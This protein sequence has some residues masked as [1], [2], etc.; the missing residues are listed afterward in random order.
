MLKKFDKNGDVELSQEEQ[1]V[2]REA[3]N[4][5]WIKGE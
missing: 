2:A 1:N 4:G 3:M 5:S